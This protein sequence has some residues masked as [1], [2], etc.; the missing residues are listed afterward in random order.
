MKSGMYNIK[1]FNGIR[2]LCVLAVFLA[3]KCDFNS[4][5]A[6]IGV[7]TFLIISG[8]LIVGELHRARINIEANLYDTKAALGIFLLKRASRVFP[9]YYTLLA[10]LF[11]VNLIYN[12]N[13]TKVGFI[14]HA[15]YL[16]NFYTAYISNFIG[17]PFGVLW[18]LS[19][20]QQY[21]V[22]IPLL[23]LF[24]QSKRH[25][26]IC[27]VIVFLSFFGQMFMIMKGIPAGA[28][29][30]TG[31]W[32]FALITIGG[33]ASIKSQKKTGNIFNSALASVVCLI[34]TLFYVIGAL[35]V[36]QSEISRQVFAMSVGVALCVLILW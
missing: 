31:P 33:I 21:Y 26:A 28:V 6:A 27:I 8:F 5:I 17:T 29:Y 18:T 11:L 35:E 23:I 22:F 19:V 2:G 10:I 14:W 32:N 20:E 13:E 3:H 1:G 4:N 34:L 15:A 16:S 7:W 30:L 25:F 36:T 9:A 24:S 12:L